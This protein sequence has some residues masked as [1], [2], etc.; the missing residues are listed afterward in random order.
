MRS[1]H[2]CGSTPYAEPQGWMQPL[3]HTLG[4]LLLEDGRFQEAEGVYR[5]DLA[6]HADNGWSLHGLAECLRRLGRAEEAARV[7]KQF[8]TVWTHS[9]I[10]IAASC[11]CR[12]GN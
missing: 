10:E 8:E 6:R 7:Q 3:R 4:V 12:S 11:F 1:T 2:G 9:D 5:A